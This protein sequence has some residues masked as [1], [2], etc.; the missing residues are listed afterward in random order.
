MNLQS[1][2]GSLPYS[3]SCSEVAARACSLV[4]LE[5]TKTADP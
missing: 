2:L 4:S 5:H 3:Q 1:W